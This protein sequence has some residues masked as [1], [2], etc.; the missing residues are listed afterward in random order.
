MPRA[1]TTGASTSVPSSGY[2][3]VLSWD[4][5]CCLR[6]WDAACTR[7]R[8]HTLAICASVSR[9]MQCLTKARTAP[10][11]V[12]NSLQ[13][14][15]RSP[16]SPTLA[17]TTGNSV[18][19][20]AVPTSHLFGGTAL[21]GQNGVINANLKFT[22]PRTQTRK[23]WVCESLRGLKFAFANFKFAPS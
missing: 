21:S 12:A 7:A 13:T 8:A 16:M 2:S 15:W 19:P 1:I 23:L 9:H 5:R 20:L 4:A 10:R 14:A 3:S 17:E 6:C 18:S 11:V 22:P